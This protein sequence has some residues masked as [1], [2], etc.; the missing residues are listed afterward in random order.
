MASL[1]LKGGRPVRRH[2]L[3]LHR[4]DFDAAESEA[5]VRVLGSGR[6]AGDGAIGR[7]LERLLCDRLGAR[8]V[9]LMNSCTAA[10]ETAVMALDLGPGDE[11]LLP[12]FTFVSCANAILRA[13]AKPVFVDIE[14]VTCNIDP[15]CLEKA[16]GP[17]TKAVMVVHYAGMAAQMERIQAITDRHGL[18][19]IEDAAHAMAATYK[20]RALSTFGLAGCLSFHETKDLVCGEGG[21]LVIRDD[22]ALAR[23]AEIIR[24][25]GTDRSAFLRGERDKYTWVGTGSSYVLSDI[26]AAVALE[27]FRK[28]D[29]IRRRK[30]EHAEALRSALAPYGSVLR[31]PV[32]PADCRPNW[33]LFA[34]Q[35]DP[36]QRDWVLRALVAEGIGA[37]FHFVPLHSSPYAREIGI[38]GGE[39]PV[40]DRVA[41]SL[42]RLPLFA[43][44]TADDRKDIVSAVDKIA[45][46]VAAHV[47]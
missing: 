4:P 3:P 18:M 5:I 39:L 20:G 32:V 17:A 43:R 16:V 28:I 1:A 14:P 46:A 33:H 19:V 7:E 12:S 38:Q 35:V 40:T 44:M 13:G 31:L 47:A 26:L 22:E 30:T 11:V 42:V 34:V 41:S 27:Q 21:A 8:H 23:R 6:G 9:L 24:E 15:A 10:L 36:A 45:E 2:R 25:K 37:A 29:E